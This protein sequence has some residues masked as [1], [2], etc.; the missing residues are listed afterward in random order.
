VLPNLDFSQ[1]DSGGL[2]DEADM[3]HEMRMS[4]AIAMSSFNKPSLKAQNFSNLFDE[5]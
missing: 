3:T 1:L 4:S 5:N 2:R